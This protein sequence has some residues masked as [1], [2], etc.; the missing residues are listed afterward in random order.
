MAERSTTMSCP[1]FQY[2]KFL[3]TFQEHV[4]LSRSREHVTNAWVSGL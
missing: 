4:E 2:T 3:E 1:C